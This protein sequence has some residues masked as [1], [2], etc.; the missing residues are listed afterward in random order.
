MTDKYPVPVLTD[1]IQCT[2]ENNNVS[3]SLVLLSGFCQIK[4]DDKS[5]P[6]TA[7]STLSGHYQYPRLATGLVSAVATLQRLINTVFAGMLDKNLFSRRDNL[8]VVSE[9]NE[10]HF[11][12]LFQVF[13]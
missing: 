7:F 12:H 1:L 5:K 9:S 10:D 6:L 3:S 8:K 13:S 2:G 11:T 4:L